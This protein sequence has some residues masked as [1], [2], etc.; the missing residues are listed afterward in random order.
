VKIDKQIADAESEY[1]KATEEYKKNPDSRECLTRSSKA[2]TSL[3]VA[4]K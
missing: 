3:K 2:R 1:K 4:K